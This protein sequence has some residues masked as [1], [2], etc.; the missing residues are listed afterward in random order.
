MKQGSQIN[1]L[2]LRK[3]AMIRVGHRDFVLGKIIYLLLKVDSLD[4]TIIC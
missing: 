1:L 2:V 3:P 4:L